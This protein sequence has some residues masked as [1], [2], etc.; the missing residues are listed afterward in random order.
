MKRSI[1]CAYYEIIENELGYRIVYYPLENWYPHSYFTKSLEKKENMFITD[2][3]IFIK[4]IK[5]D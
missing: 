1:I 5:H 2:D 3:Y 4:E